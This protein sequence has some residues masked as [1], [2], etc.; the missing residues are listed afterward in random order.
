MGILGEVAFVTDKM[1]GYMQKVIGMANSEGRFDIFSASQTEDDIVL[2]MDAKRRGWL[3]VKAYNSR[4]TKSGYGAYL[5]EK[6]KRDCRAEEAAKEAKDRVKSKILE[7]AVAI[8]LA[9]IT[10]I[11]GVVAAHWFQ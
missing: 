7:V 9:V 10:S 5:A 6:E 2:L 4:V 8:L 3:I 1:F 11:A